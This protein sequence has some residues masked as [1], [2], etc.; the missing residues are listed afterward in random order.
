MGL[1]LL[2]IAQEPEDFKSLIDSACYSNVPDEADRLVH[3]AEQLIETN[4]QA[5]D[6]KS[7][8]EN[9]KESMKEHCDN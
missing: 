6:W 3:F 9:I 8:I 7:G 5:L 2:V 4:G 1:S